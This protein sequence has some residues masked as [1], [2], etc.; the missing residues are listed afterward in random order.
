MGGVP[1]SDH[2]GRRPVPPSARPRRQESE[3]RRPQE[4]ASAILKLTAWSIRGLVSGQM[5]VADDTLF[6]TRF[7]G[8]A[9]LSLCRAIEPVIA[10]SAS[11]S[12]IRRRSQVRILDRPLL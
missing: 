3:G 8:F 10:G 5:V 11:A 12:L 7:R 4:A 9:G 6:E 2:G 1:S